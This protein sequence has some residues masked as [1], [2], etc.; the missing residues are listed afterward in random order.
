MSLF[1]RIKNY[2]NTTS[3][4]FTTVMTPF[5]RNRQSASLYCTAFAACTRIKGDTL[6]ILPGHSYRMVGATR[7]LTKTPL[8]RFMRGKWND[9]LTASEGMR[10]L[11][12]ELD[13]SGNA[14]VYVDRSGANVKG[15]Y[16]LTGSM[17]MQYDKKRRR[18]I[19]NYM[20]DEF[21]DAGI[22]TSRNILHFK[23]NILEH[24]G[25]R[26]ISIAHLLRNQINISLDMDDFYRRVL[27]Q[28]QHS[29]GVIEISKDVTGPNAKNLK[30]S[31]QDSLE[32]REGTEN[33]GRALVLPPGASY[34]A[35]SMTMVESDLTSQ[36]K[37]NIAEI[38]RQHGVPPYMIYE[39]GDQKYANAQEA[40]L[41][42]AK[43]TITP[44]VKNIEDVL[45]AY[46]ALLEMPEY[47]IKFDLNGLMRGDFLTRV[48]AYQIL[49]Q[50]GIY[51]PNEIRAY[52]DMDPHDGGDYLR[53]D[54]NAGRILSDGTVEVPTT[55]KQNNRATAQAQTLFDARV[56][57]AHKR[58]SARIERDGVTDKNVRYA[59]E[60]AQPLALAAQLSDGVIQ[61][62][63]DQFIT[64]ATTERM[65]DA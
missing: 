61:F 57:D 11:I 6:S 22:Y 40:S 43:F 44:I 23:S 34:K 59:R 65:Q 36:Q 42:F 41:N 30:K 9:M 56:D 54:L 2:F 17:L 32:N 49:V 52:E 63:I 48:R 7:E 55:D 28:G 5:F 29:P 33:A 50:S 1:A 8:D 24:N 27:V 38:C 10:W 39:G 19:Y 37:H 62:D 26:G 4:S 35:M 53:I 60:L 25:A 45:N 12:R 64:E 13:T 16:Q 46:L 58:I 3:P 21:I 47:Y 31:L 15:L 18:I 51:T 14:Y 20:G